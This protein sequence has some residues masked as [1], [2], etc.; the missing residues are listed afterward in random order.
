MHPGVTRIPGN[1][2]LFA[3]IKKLQFSE[4]VAVCDD[5]VHCTVYSV[6]PDNVCDGYSD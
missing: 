1:L 2:S 4:K 5:I 6:D 3:K